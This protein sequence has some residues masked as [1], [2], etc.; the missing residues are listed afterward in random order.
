MRLAS[1]LALALVSLT[2]CLSDDSPDGIDEVGVDSGKADGSQL[3]ECETREILAYLNEGVTA[4]ALETAGVHARAAGALT[5]YRD[6]ADARFGTD[7]DDLFDSIDEVDEVAYVGRT[8][9]SQLV[10]AT[11]PRCAVPTDIFAD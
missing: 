1:T 8:A 10:T 5:A 9:F 2:G 4:D 3:T 11:A 6:G 7:D